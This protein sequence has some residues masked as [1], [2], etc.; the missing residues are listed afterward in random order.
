MRGPTSV[1]AAEQR[2]HLSALPRTERVMRPCPLGRAPFFRPPAPAV[3]INQE[4][5]HGL[6][7]SNPWR[8]GANVRTGSEPRRRNR[9]PVGEQTQEWFRTMSLAI[10]SL[11]LRRRLRPSR[12]SLIAAIMRNHRELG[13]VFAHTE[14]GEPADA[15]HKAAEC[16]SAIM[17]DR[18]RT[19]LANLERLLTAEFQRDDPEIRL[20]LQRSAHGSP[21]DPHDER[22][23]L[24]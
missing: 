21:A 2:P 1:Q 8:N 4:T 13:S 6:L 24:A 12:R 7:E 17:E 9:R 20:T 22:E 3:P 18:I 16:A 23:D 5:D 19:D 15:F 10:M 14:F 11:L